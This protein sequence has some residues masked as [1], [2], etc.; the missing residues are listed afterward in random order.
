MAYAL[1]GGLSNDI[2]FQIGLVTLIA[3]AAKNAILIVEFAQHKRE[4]EGLSIIESAVQAAKL[5]FRPIVMTSLAFGI[6]VLPLAISSG[7]GAASRHAIGTGVIGGVLAT[8]FI[9][10][11]FIPLFWTYFARL[12]EFLKHKF[13]K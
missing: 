4:Q 9:G 8:T 1:C 12:S 5:R 2:Y 6:G 7:A 11:F 10:T 13:A 3:I